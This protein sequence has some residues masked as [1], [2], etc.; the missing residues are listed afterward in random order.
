M[1]KKQ[2]TISIADDGSVDVDYSGF[3]AWEVIG[4][5]R[6]ASLHE[7]EM[8]RNLWE[9]K[10]AAEPPRENTDSGETDEEQTA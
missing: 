7:E 4:L 10:K 1:A 3:A 5:L 8:L 9:R 2:I 6:F